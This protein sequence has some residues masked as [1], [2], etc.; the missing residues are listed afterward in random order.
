[1]HH[2]RQVM[3]SYYRFLVKLNETKLLASHHSWASSIASLLV[4]HNL[5]KKTN[6]NK[7]FKYWQERRTSHHPECWDTA[8][9]GQGLYGRSSTILTP[10]C[11]NECLIPQRT[12]TTPSH[13]FW[14]LGYPSNF[15]LLP[16]IINDSQS[17]PW[18]LNQNIWPNKS[19][20][21]F[22]LSYT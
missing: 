6:E 1:M 19:R 17:N 3:L 13:R 12:Q 21:G 2:M 5:Q 9:M 15:M 7:G 11:R 4:S 8:E 18:T 20:L 14:I 10:K 22:N 16:L